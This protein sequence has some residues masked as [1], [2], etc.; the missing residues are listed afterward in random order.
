M[1]S[2]TLANCT[3][4]EEFGIAFEGR[5]APLAGGHGLLLKRDWT[6]ISLMKLVQD[7]TQAID[8]ARVIVEGPNVELPPRKAISTYLALH[9]LVTNA[10]KYGALSQNRGKV[11]V[12]WD[13]NDKATIRLI[14]QESG[15]RLHG[16]SA[17]A[18]API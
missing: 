16:R 15:G 11:T 13:L 6:S 17:K 8:P 14:W 5:L 7:A 10:A 18:S 1:A 2:Q 9:E 3:S 4:L 12:Q